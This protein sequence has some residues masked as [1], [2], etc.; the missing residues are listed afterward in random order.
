[1][2]NIK[3]KILTLKLILITVLFTVL[4]VSCNKCKKKYYSNGSIEF[5]RCE[6]VN[7]KLIKVTQF[8]LRGNIISLTYEN[9]YGNRDSIGTY[10]N[11]KGTKE[12]TIT[13]KNG[14]Y[15]GKVTLFYSNGNIR[16]IL[17]LL[18]GKLN[19]KCTFFNLD[20]II[21]KILY[22]K[23]INNESIVNSIL[24]FDK[25]KVINKDSTMYA[26]ILL[27]KDTVLIN[28]YIN[29]EFIYFNPSG[30]ASIEYANFDKNFNIQ[31][32]STI[33]YLNDS[34][35]PF[36]IK[37]TK[38]GNDTLRVIYKIQDLKTK[39]LYPIYLEKPFYVK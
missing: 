35:S 38:K 16:E 14:H 12:K 20:G 39:M 9:E 29:F 1:M 25:P 32:S 21:N 22:Y 23:I 33:K 18:D 5:E 19:G 26:D 6:Q 8:D 28:D 36:K 4:L 11:A 27:K 34:N 30:L 31:D 3:N 37:A 7:S 17:N 2:L 10:F 24:V 13:F 15:T